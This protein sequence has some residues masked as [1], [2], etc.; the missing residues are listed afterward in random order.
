MPHSSS[1]SLCACIKT[2][3]RMRETDRMS[4]PQKPVRHFEIIK[5]PNLC[6]RVR[7]CLGRCACV[8][9]LYEWAK[10]AHDV[11][12]MQRKPYHHWIWLFGFYWC[13]C[14]VFALVSGECAK[15][16][17]LTMWTIAHKHTHMH[18]PSSHYNRQYSR[19]DDGIARVWRESKRVERIFDMPKILILL[20]LDSDN[21]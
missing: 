19:I 20:L 8:C 9:C 13:L 2:R 12:L 15:E 1:A 5:L 21:S 17:R 3:M 7:V 4:G 14:V 11:V 6:D 18:S 16:A 10:S